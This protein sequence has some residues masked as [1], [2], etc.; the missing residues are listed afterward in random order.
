MVTA[1]S[2][3]WTNWKEKVLWCS[4]FQSFFV[5]CDLLSQ[6]VGSL[7]TEG[8]FLLRLFLIEGFLGAWRRWNCPVVHKKTKRSKKWTLCKRHIFFVPHPPLLQGKVMTLFINW[9]EVNVSLT[10]CSFRATHTTLLHQH[11]QKQRVLLAVSCSTLLKW[12]PVEQTIECFVVHCPSHSLTSCTYICTHAQI[13]YTLL[14]EVMWLTICAGVTN[15]G[16]CLASLLS[17]TLMRLSSV[18]MQSLSGQKM[19]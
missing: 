10:G 14:P 19:G 7:T 1:F 16:R 11:T 2:A 4:G 3:F 18:S 17:W 8:M 13:L 5:A 9:S 15:T 12:K 6:V